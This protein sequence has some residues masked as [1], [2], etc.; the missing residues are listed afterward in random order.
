MSDQELLQRVRRRLAQDAA[1]VTGAAV[2]GAVRAQPGKAPLGATALLDLADRVYDQLL[3]AG[4]LAALVADPATTDIVVNGP[5]QVWVD[6]GNGMV[7]AE[8]GFADA[9]ALRRF[10]QRLAAACGR[11]LDDSSPYV[12]ARLPDGTRLHAVLPPAAVDG[13]YLSLRTF[14]RQTYTLDDLVA[15][16]TPTPA[17]A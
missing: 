17:A 5:D 1:P 11:R 6:R 15:A 8:G 14:R 7:R 2:V 13:P 3:G 9:D 16:C 10:A 12:D 4:P